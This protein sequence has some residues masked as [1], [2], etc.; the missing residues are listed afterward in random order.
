MRSRHYTLT[1]QDVYAYVMRHLHR[2]L[3]VRDLSP[4]CMAAMLLS[5]QGTATAGLTSLAVATR[6][7]RDRR[8][9]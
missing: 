1:R 3:V 7:L 9:R 8:N 4:C 2:H 6:R 5:A